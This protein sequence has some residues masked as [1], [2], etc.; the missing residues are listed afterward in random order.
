MFALLAVAF[1]L[2]FV[3][4]GVGSG[5]TGISDALQNAFH[6]GGSSTSISSLQ[7]KVA[8]HPENATD[9]RNLATAYETKQRTQDA[10]NALERFTALK[11]KNADAL[12]ELAS[13]YAALVQTNYADY[14][15]ALA[16]TLRQPRE[17]VP[18]EH[19]VGVRQGVRSSSV[20]KSPI[21]TAV[22]DAGDVE[23]QQPE[24]NLSAAEQLTVSA[25]QRLAKLTPK[26][27][28]TQLQLGQYAQA[29]GNNTVA[30]AAFKK[31]LKLAPTDVEAPTVRSN[32]KTLL[33][34]TGAST[35][36]PSG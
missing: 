11:P 35:T 15:N 25:Y 13:Q 12:G 1:G 23:P 17:P 16:A 26:D 4:F 3:I 36:A 10:I 14:Q 31:F 29:A 5:S 27:A 8:K 28:T 20:P 7:N 34:S 9:W 22:E 21:D 32:L 2:G 33:K 24:P 19:V 30:I 18:A 6:F